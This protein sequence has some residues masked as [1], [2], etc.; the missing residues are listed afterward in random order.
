MLDVLGTWIGGERGIACIP[1]YTC[2]MCH[3]CQLRV[4]MA[5]AMLYPETSQDTL[6][7]FASRPLSGA[8]EAAVTE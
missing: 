7:V 1:H 2:Y 5:P 3:G 4:G 6:H 8:E